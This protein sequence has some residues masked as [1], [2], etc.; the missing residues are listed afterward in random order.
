MNQAK[1]DSLPA[2]LK[3]VIDNNSGLG[4]SQQIGRIWD[5]SQAPGRKAA[6]DRG[7]T[8]YMIPASELDNWIKASAPLHEEWVADMTKR[9]LPGKQ[10]LEDAK[11]LLA[12]YKR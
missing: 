7:N 9:G 2:E 3:K 5:D 11:A 6:V 4:L 12:K 10:M 8:F 1:Y